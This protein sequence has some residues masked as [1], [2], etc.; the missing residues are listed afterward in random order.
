MMPLNIL[1]AALVVASLLA[2]GVAAIILGQRRDAGQR[3][4]LRCGHYL[5]GGHAC[6][7]KWVKT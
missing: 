7:S 5:K 1:A 6:K 2:L 3:R 4:C